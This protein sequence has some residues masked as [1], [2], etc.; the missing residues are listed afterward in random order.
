MNAGTNGYS[1]KEKY[2]RVASIYGANASGKSNL[3]I[4]MRYFQQIIM[5]SMNSSDDGSETAISHYYVPFLFEEN[6]DNS[7]FQIVIIE[8]EYEYRYGFEYNAECIVMEWLYRKSLKTN[9]KATIFE[10]TAETV[11]FGASVRKECDAYKDQ[12]PNETLALTFF[13]KLRLKTE[14]FKNVYMGIMNNRV[15]LSSF[16]TDTDL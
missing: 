15:A 7:E 14:I 1:Q 2:L 8:G 4:A 12:I 10:R 9:R 6:Y 16:D 11:Q 3:V 5:Q 13:N